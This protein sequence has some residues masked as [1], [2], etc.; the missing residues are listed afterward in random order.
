MNVHHIFVHFSLAIHEG[1][2]TKQSQSEKILVLQYATLD[3]YV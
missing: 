1:Q 2:Q 3:H